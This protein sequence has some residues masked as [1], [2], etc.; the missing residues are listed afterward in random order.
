MK[1]RTVFQLLAAGFLILPLSA[2]AETLSVCATNCD[3][4]DVQAA[5]QAAQE[6]DVIEITD[7]RTYVQN[8]NLEYRSSLTIR[9]TGD[10]RPTIK[11]T[12]LYMSGPVVKIHNADHVTLERLLITGPA[13][14]TDGLVS[15]VGSTGVT[16]ADSDLSGGQR[17]S[18]G[19]VYCSNSTG[20]TVV[21]TKIHDNNGGGSGGGV[22]LIGCTD[23][24]LDRVEIT[25]NFANR[26]GGL[27]LDAASSASVLGGSISF[28]R[29]GSA[30]LVGGGINTSG[31][32][33]VSGSSISGNTASHQGGGV[34]VARGS[35]TITDSVISGNTVTY[36][37][38][39]G[40]IFV[41]SYAGT[42]LNLHRSRIVSNRT[43]GQGGG[44]YCLGAAII[45]DCIV[46][47]NVA[48]SQGGG[49]FSSATTQLKH[50]TIAGNSAYAYGG[51]YGALGSA[52]NSIFWGNCPSTMV[53]GKLIQHSDV[54]GGYAG[55]GNVNYDPS[56][57]APLN[58][59]DAPTVEGNYHIGILS[60]VIDMASAS[61]ATTSDIDG[62]ERGALP[63]IGADEVVQNC[64]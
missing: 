22:D 21:E 24:T 47:G 53:S 33:T 23:V 58:C 52:Y 64:P 41:N 34:C 7:G 11:G 28:N 44:A 38:G 55:E 31:T 14:Y 10:M 56:F 50:V 15:I 17:L 5:I 16:I 32:L 43:G 6:G 2:R 30:M 29:A 54:E 48:A 46:S 45:T 62:Q 27:S 26:G 59:L 42:V 9:G 60:P 18:G 39:G 61:F 1:M 19:G 63:D 51:L 35:T 4:T 57:I 3:H 25:Y 12:G 49:I 13:Y 36:Y 37:S 8:L 40:G 20:V